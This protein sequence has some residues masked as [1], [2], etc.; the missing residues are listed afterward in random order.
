MGS[1]TLL[2]MF[3]RITIQYLS[4]YPTVGTYTTSYVG[5]SGYTGTQASMLIRY[6][7]NEQSLLSSILPTLRYRIIVR[8]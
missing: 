1:N 4:R 5:C 8:W 7:W 3:V 2:T 6:G